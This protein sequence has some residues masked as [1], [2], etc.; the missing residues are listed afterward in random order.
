M[1]AAEL[2]AEA[3]AHGHASAG[4][5][6]CLCDAITSAIG[7]AAAVDIARARGFGEADLDD[8]QR[9]AGRAVAL[10]AMFLHAN[11]SPIPETV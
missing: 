7:I 2:T 6:R 11:T 8:L 5:R 1:A 4:R 3:L 9:T 10:L